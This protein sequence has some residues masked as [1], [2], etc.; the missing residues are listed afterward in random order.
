MYDVTIRL[1]NHPGALANV[2]EVLGKAGISVEGGGGWVVSGEATMHFLFAD[3]DAARRA[4]EAA[5]VE[6]LD[7]RKVLVQKLDQE[8]PGQ[9]GSISRA[10][11]DAGVNIDTLYSDHANQLVMVVDDEAA[12]QA[13]SDAWKASGTASR[14]PP[15]QHVYRTG[16]R[17]TG[18][19]GTGTDSYTTYTRDHEI[20]ADGKATIMAS[21]DP[22][23]RGDAARWNPEEMLVAAISSCHQLWYLHLCAKAGIIVTAYEDA[24][25]GI[26]EEVGGG[27]GKFISAVLRP[28]MRITDISRREEALALHHPAHEL[29]YIAQSVNFPVTCEPEVM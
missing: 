15:R 8:K 1:E 22:A 18:N 9:L 2:G 5:G 4:L 23:F 19:T 3:G 26:M 10:M 7:V 24:A 14:R 13:V 11:A 16:L 20:V 25:E 12:G 29:C 21:S 27:G 6:V 17:W 28:R